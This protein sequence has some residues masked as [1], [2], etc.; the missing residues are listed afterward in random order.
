MFACY[1]G[2]NWFVKGGDQIYRKKKGLEPLGRPL[3]ELKVDSDYFD[4][5]TEEQNYI[6]GSVPTCPIGKALMTRYFGQD[7]SI[8]NTSTIASLK[9]LCIFIYCV[10]N[11]YRIWNIASESSSLGRPKA[12]GQ[13][14]WTRTQGYLWHVS[15][16]PPCSGILDKILISTLNLFHVWSHV[17]YSTQGHD[18]Q[19][20]GRTL[21]SQ[22]GGK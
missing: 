19:R 12:G 11:I 7:K 10:T 17:S 1:E 5:K 2:K 20:P 21:F 3:G 16:T 18:P 9:K 4:L 13:F 15:L 14:S 6:P 8:S 22:A